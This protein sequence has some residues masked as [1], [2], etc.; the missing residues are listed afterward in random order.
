MNRG[1]RFRGT[2]RYAFLELGVRFNQEATVTVIRLAVRVRVVL[3]DPGPE[4]RFD[5]VGA[6]SGPDAQRL[7]VFIEIMHGQKFSSSLYRS[8]SGSLGSSNFPPVFRRNAN[9]TTANARNP[10]NKTNE[11]MISL[12]VSQ[13]SN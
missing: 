10:T 3:F 2:R 13:L 9:K 7:A 6:I 1:G 4:G 12:P 8:S 11:A 5:H